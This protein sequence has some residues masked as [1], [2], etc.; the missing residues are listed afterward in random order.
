[1]KRAEKENE[2]E[3]RNLR[4]G[5]K[6]SISISF[7]SASVCAANALNFR[8]YIGQRHANCQFI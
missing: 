1:M 3:R 6:E 8:H 2:K 7:A 5:S 4:C